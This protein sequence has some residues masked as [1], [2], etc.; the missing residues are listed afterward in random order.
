MS[1]VRRSSLQLAAALALLAAA[2]IPATSRA[3]VVLY[4]KDGW[5]LYTRGLIAAHYEAIIGDAEPPVVG[6]RVLVGGVFAIPGEDTQAANTSNPKSPTL[7]LSRMRSGFVG[8]NIGFGVTRKI[9]DTVNVDSL[10][11]VSIND[12]SNARGQS[13][14]TNTKDVDFREAWAALHTP[15]GTLK[16]GRMFSIFGSASGQ[17]VMLA[18]RYGEGNPCLVQ[19][20]T[21]GCG[22][23]GAGPIYAEFDGQMQYISPRL[24]GFELKL[25]VVD[26]TASPDI[27]TLTPIPRFDGELNYRADF[28]ESSNLRII[29]QGVYNHIEQQAQAGAPQPSANVTGAM[30][31]ALLDVGGSWGKLQVGA[32]A[33]LGSGVGTHWIME[34]PGGGAALFLSFD[35][36]PGMLPNGTGACP[37]HAL[38][39]FRGYYGNVAYDYRGT[40]LAVGAGGVFVKATDYDKATM[41]Y[42]VLNQSIEGHVVFTQTFDAI[43]LEAEFM[44]WQSKYQAGES[45]NINF[46]G[47]GANFFW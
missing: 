42:N 38:R 10:M 27:Y 12:I 39:D 2:V 32:G 33:W 17:V 19:A 34:N 37:A 45:Q 21:I 23:V 6:G 18:F 11:D 36:C 46:A 7:T 47:V 40:A 22:S 15:Y 20:T 1:R 28:N 13:S 3:D 26:P 25:A 41:S 24:A 9:S 4:D 14:T 5:G 43:V 31:S 16:F 44:R 8:T 35:D 30:G 29:A